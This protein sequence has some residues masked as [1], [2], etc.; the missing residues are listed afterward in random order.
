MKITTKRLYLAPLS[1]CDAPQ[2]LL[3]VSDE[4]VTEFMTYSTY[5]DL[6]KVEK[7]LE[8]KI[9]D[10]ATLGVFLAD[11]TLIGTVACPVA[12]GGVR[13]IGYNLRHDC[14]GHGYCTEAVKALLA[15]AAVRFSTRNFFSMHAVEN[16]RSARVL[17]K[18]NFVPCGNGSYAKLD[19]SR[20]FATVNYRLDVNLHNMNLC[21]E[22]F[23]QI[24][25]GTKTVEMRLDDERRKNIKI[26]DYIA[27]TNNENGQIM[28]ARV[29][30]L[31]RFKS[32]AELYAAMDL[33]K[34]GYS[35]EQLASAHPNDMLQYYT[36]EQQRQYG[37]LGIEVEYLATLNI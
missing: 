34:C 19:G 23:Q 36:A 12:E 24:V 21:N 13:K 32:F 25:A 1:V 31:S 2:V 9:S 30:S 29:V 4:E 8:T 28:V 18:C 7:W 22:P 20:T 33:T 11:G 27:F 37:A 14:W 16:I 10:D 6:D 5:S 17:Q 35:A 15:Y 3:W 26:G